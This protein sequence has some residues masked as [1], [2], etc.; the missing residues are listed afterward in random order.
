VAPSGRAT[1][2]GPSR[3]VVRDFERAARGKEYAKATYGRGLWQFGGVISGLGEELSEKIVSDQYI[4]AQIELNTGIEKFFIDMDKTK[5]VEDGIPQWDK[6]PEKFESKYQQITEGI[7]NRLG[8]EAKELYLNYAEA[9]KSQALKVLES[10]IKGIRSNYFAQTMPLVIARMARAGQWEQTNQLL[11]QLK[12]GGYFPESEWQQ[13]DKIFDE[14]VIIGAIRHGLPEEVVQQMIKE[15]DSLT[16]QEKISLTRT[17][18]QEQSYRNTQAEI[19]LKK[20]QEIARGQIYDA[21]YD[22]SK[23][24]EKF[25]GDMHAFIESKTSLEEGEQELLWQLALKSK[26]VLDWD[27][28]AKVE[29]A[30]SDL[31]EGKI[32]DGKVVDE[33]YVLTVLR[34]NAEGIDNITG[35]SLIAKI[36]SAVDSE[37]PIND[38]NSRRMLSALNELKT[39]NFFITQEEIDEDAEKA[40]V[41]NLSEWIRYSNDLEDWLREN[42]TATPK[43]KEEYFNTTIKPLK[44]DAAKRL[45]WGIPRR[46]YE[47]LFTKEGWTPSRMKKGKKLE[48]EDVGLLSAPDMRLDQYWPD[49]PDIEKREI[50]K[51]LENN[52]DNIDEILRILKGG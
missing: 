48:V 16:S 12:K 23:I 4:K 9:Q 36:F 47:K 31:R 8:P 26:D 44:E 14:N 2:A 27:N 25:A 33:D 20:K 45:L 50:I 29:E 49:L 1:T 22:H 7:S 39:N 43:Q 52:P 42:P 6:I 51:A 30:I 35:K 19:A 34:E 3:S 17:Q 37:D 21:N 38:S 10:K 41:K 32:I 40:R 18:R 11:N 5:W 28:Y 15:A 24:P 46:F 13:L